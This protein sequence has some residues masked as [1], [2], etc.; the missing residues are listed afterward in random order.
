MTRTVDVNYWLGDNDFGE[1]FY[2]FWLHEDLQSLCGVDV[3]QSLWLRWTRPAMGLRLSPYQACQGAL[4]MK[5]KAL[6]E[7]F[8]HEN[9]AFAW[10]T[11]ELNVPGSEGYRPERPWISKRRRDGN[12]A[13]AG[14][15]VSLTTVAA[16]GGEQQVCQDGVISWVAGY[17]SET[18][19]AQQ[20]TRDVVWLV[21]G[22]H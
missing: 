14:V 2:N 12:I 8:D 7:P 17:P 3:T 19:F 1:M 9:N 18:T 15:H 4:R 13:A 16:Q 20:A 11:V 22:D 10:E 5:R 6:G 21:C